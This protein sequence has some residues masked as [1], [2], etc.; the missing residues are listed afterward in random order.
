MQNWFRVSMYR[1]IWWS[2]KNV[3]ARIVKQLNYAYIWKCLQFHRQ[4]IK[5][6][7]NCLTNC[8]ILTTLKIL[9]SFDQDVL[10]NAAVI[11]VKKF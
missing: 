9:L 3:K 1:D 6:L 5:L 7:Y 8:Y 4:I 2:Y 10:T 11:Y